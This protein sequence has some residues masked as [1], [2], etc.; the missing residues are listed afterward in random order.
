MVTRCASYV[1]GRVLRVTRLDACGRVVYGPDSVVTSAGFVSVAYTANI[2]DGE[3]INLPNANGDRCVYVPAKPSF[4]GYTAEITFCNVDPDLFAMMTGQR[5]VT[6]AFGDVVGFTM[7]TAVSSDDSAFALEVW[8]GSP[9]T[10]GCA[11]GATGNFGYVLLPFLQGGVVG[12][13]T[14]ENAEVTFTI[15]NASTK[16]GNAWGVG[17]Y[18]VVLGADSLP[19]PLPDPL[20]PTEHLYFVQTGVAPP[21]PECG[22]RPLLDPDA[23]ALTDVTATPTGLS[24]EFDPTPASTDP[25]WIDFGDGTWEYSADGSAITHVYPADATYDWIAYRNDSTVEGSVV[26][27]APV[28]TLASILPVSGP[29]AG[30]T[31]VVGTGTGFVGATGVTVGGVAATAVSVVNATTINFTT[32]A[33]TIG[34]ATVVVLHPSGNGTLVDGFEY[35]A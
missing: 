12:D 22:A 28:A 5:V 23:D 31:A 6:D 21:E 10:T 35:T 25:W 27:D 15:S 29:A 34:D 4:L 13:F 2:D 26:V 32:P 24:V 33:G 1:R 7:D 17:P 30:G 14:I 20:T 11:E 8:A 3:E 19:A 9:T 16:D 18:D